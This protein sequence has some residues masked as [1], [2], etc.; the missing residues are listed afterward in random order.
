[1]LTL[2]GV[3]YKDI[4]YIDELKIFKNKITCIIGESGGGKTTL[5]K[6]LNNMITCDE[7]EIIID[8]TSIYSINPIELRR[9]MIMMSQNPPVYNG[10][11]KDNLLMGLVF[12]EKPL[13]EDS[14]LMDVLKSVNLR[15]GLLENVSNLSGGEKQ[16]LALARVLLME[17]EILLL[18]EPSSALDEEMGNAVIEKV[19]DYIKNEDKTLIMVTHAKSILEKFAENIIEVNNRKVISHKE[20]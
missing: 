15:K 8:G 19:V 12:S 11:I 6:L 10:T 9:K 7:G 17:P 4:L 5:L 18:D 2:K 1:M 16:R 20:S 13:V 3:K 14:K